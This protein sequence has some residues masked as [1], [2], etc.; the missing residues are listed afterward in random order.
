[1]FRFLDPLQ[2]TALPA[3]LFLVWLPI[4]LALRAGHARVFFILA[5]IATLVV[6]AGPPLTIGLA[7]IILAGY[8]LT[9]GVARLHAGRTAAF[10]VALAL[11]HAGYWACFHLMIPGGYVQLPAPQAPGVY[12]LFSGIGLTF[13]R[14]IAYLHDRV[15]RHAP[16]LSLLDYLAYMFFFPQFRHGPIERARDFAPRLAAAR[17]TWNPRA[18]A[19][20][21][22]RVGWGVGMLLIVR[23]VFRHSLPPE[24]KNSPFRF[25]AELAAD[26]AQLSFWRLMLLIHVPGLLLYFLE[27]SAAHMQLGVSRVFGVRGTENFRAPWLA[28]SPRDVWQRWNVTFSA[29]LRDYG[30]LPLCRRTRHRLL[31]LVPTFLYGGLLHGLQWRCV[32]WGLYAGVTLGAYTWLDDRLRKRRPR[33]APP[34]RSSVGRALGNVLLRLVTI[35]WACIGV[36]MFLDPEY[37]GFRILRHYGH[38]IVS[39][40]FGT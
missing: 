37:C 39:A 10:V 15:R 1:M 25:L 12:I 14:L 40:I 26:P 29:W 31:I 24:Y 30:Y 13:F 27:S 4:F 8:G 3:T 17:Q 11:V 38:L 34:P 16:S 9:E 20:G 21:L 2:P 35:H 5:S 23:Y 36:T 32:V 7:L 33:T 28:T 6:V 22:I 18:A 19:L